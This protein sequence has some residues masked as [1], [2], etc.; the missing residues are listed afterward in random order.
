MK[1]KIK[2]K[3]GFTLIE[4][5]VVVLII[6]ILAAIALPQYRYAVL[7]SRYNTLKISTRAIYDA[8]QRYYLVN[9]TY[10]TDI[11]NLD[12]EINS[13]CRIEND[14]DIQCKKGSLMHKI[15]KNGKM[16]CYVFS[17]DQNDI[18]NKVCKLE[19][20]HNSASCKSI[21]TTPYCMYYY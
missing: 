7:K 14:F 15:D 17:L 4:L 13:Y 21:A 19:T 9:G 12:I 1:Q 6:G 10:T 8:E 16:L 5:L 20:G 11:N 18:L 3:K 2:T